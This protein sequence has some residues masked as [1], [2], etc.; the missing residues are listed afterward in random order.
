[1]ITTDWSEWRE[2]VERSSKFLLGTAKELSKDKIDV[3]TPVAMTEDQMVEFRHIYKQSARKIG[4]LYT[5]PI[6]LYTVTVHYNNLLWHISPAYWI[7]DYDRYLRAN[8]S[9]SLPSTIGEIT[10]G[11]IDAVQKFVRFKAGNCD[12]AMGLISKTKG[13]SKYYGYKVNDNIYPYKVV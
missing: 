4:Y 6:L 12:D 7:T 1:M 8:F 10:E 13:D 2:N 11:G 9:M 5:S 3:I